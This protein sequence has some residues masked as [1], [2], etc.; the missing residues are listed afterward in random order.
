[1]LAAFSCGTGCSSLRCFLFFAPIA[2]LMLYHAP[3]RG[4][5]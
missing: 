4:S 5:R 2:A 3:H 1:M